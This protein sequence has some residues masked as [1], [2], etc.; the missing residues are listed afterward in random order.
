MIGTPNGAHDG[1]ML[2]EFIDGVL[3]QMPARACHWAS[4]SVCGRI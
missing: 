1:A 3:D 4:A 2:V